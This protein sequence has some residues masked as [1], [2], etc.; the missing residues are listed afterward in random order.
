MKKI[1]LLLVL[2]F[3][4]LAI[5]TSFYFKNIAAQENQSTSDSNPVII[6]KLEKILEKQTAILNQI[7]DL[8]KEIKARC[9]R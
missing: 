5:S 7:E 1:L 4:F 8:K 3:V 9:T 6:E 2:L